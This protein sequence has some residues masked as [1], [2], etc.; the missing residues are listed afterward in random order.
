MMAAWHGAASYLYGL[1]RLS[2]IEYEITLDLRDKKAVH[3]H[4]EEKTKDMGTRM[5]LKRDKEVCICR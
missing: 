3:F 1:C 5:F 2:R 4:C